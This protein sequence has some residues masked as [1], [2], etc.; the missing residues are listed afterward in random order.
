MTNEHTSL[1]K[2]T[3]HTLFERVAKGLRKGCVWGV[4]WKLNR[5]QHIDPQFLWLQ[6]HFFLILL[7][8]STGDPEGPSPLLGAGSH[9]LELQLELQ[10]QLTPTNSNCLWHR[11]CIPW[12]SQLHWIQPVHGQGY[13]FDRMYLFL[14]WRLGRRSICYIGTKW[15]RFSRDCNVTLKRRRYLL[16]SYGTHRKNKWIKE[17]KEN[18]QKKK[19]N[20]PQRRK[21]KKMDTLWTT[22]TPRFHAFQQNLYRV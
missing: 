5:Q 20:R 19:Y 15:E 8:C 13:I 6:Q 9:C 11:V 16:P 4:S 17:D 2:Y 18:I 3:S 21:N 22:G 14:Y 12:A 10:L 1:E 7:G